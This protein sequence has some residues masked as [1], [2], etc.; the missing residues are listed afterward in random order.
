MFIP[1]TSGEAQTGYARSN[2]ENQRL[3]KRRMKPGIG[4]DTQD[5]LAIFPV[6]F[7]LK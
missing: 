4:S 7:G 3:A 5:H 6:F 2:V 1:M